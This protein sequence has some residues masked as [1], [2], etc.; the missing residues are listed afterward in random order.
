MDH[1]ISNSVKDISNKLNDYSK[2]IKNMENKIKQNTSQKQSQAR[3][4]RRASFN[5][6]SIYANNIIRAAGNTSETSTHVSSNA[7][8]N[9]LRKW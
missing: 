2:E 8:V 4:S 6:Q 1:K 3:V 9:S 7:W 5:Y